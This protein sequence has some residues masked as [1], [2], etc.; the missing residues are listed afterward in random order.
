MSKN[1]PETIR[2]QG[3]AVNKLLELGDGDAALL[4]LYQATGDETP[5][6]KKLNWGDDRLQAAGKRLAE[7]GLFPAV[8]PTRSNPDTKT[9]AEKE[10]YKLSQ[11]VQRLFGRILSSDELV[12][13]FR[14]YDSLGLAPEV[15]L[16]LVVYCTAETQGRGSASTPSMKYIEKAA[17]TW[18]REGIV[19]LELAE[20]YIKDR[21]EKKQESSKIKAALQIYDRGLTPTERKYIDAWQEL[22][23]TS[24]AIAIAYD[25]TVTQTGKLSW[26]YMNSIISSWH[27][28][29][30]HTAEEI[31]E[32][33]TRQ[34]GA[35]PS[36]AGKNTP[37]EN[38]VLRLSRIISKLD[39]PK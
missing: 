13:L 2:L 10:F 38:E 17:Y 15:I 6:Q 14:L 28:K 23:Y 24:E 22:G 12:R 18:E 4:Y 21:A 26:S 20:S 1:I 35:K 32:R 31:L 33:D 39:E 25:R 29:N 9:S 16:Q 27:G 37:D 36:A 11:E 3:G 5:M 8:K 19:T 34:G 7:L 30:L